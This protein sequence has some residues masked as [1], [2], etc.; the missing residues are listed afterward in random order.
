M[1]RS[2]TW[3]EWPAKVCSTWQCEVQPQAGA[4]VGSGADSGLNLLQSQ[5]SPTGAGQGSVGGRFGDE[6]GSEFKSQLCTSK[7]KKRGN[8]SNHLIKTRNNG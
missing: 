1:L 2:G 5:W 6:V 3:T 8:N 7:Y 4:R